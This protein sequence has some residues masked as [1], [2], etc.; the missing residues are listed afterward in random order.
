MDRYLDITGVEGVERRPGGRVHVL[1]CH[2][3]GG[4]HED[5]IAYLYAVLESRVFAHQGVKQLA[6]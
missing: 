1:Y 4:I 3:A 5:V 2:S 6:V